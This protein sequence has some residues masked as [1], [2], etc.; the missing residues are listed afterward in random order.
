MA[1]TGQTMKENRL[2]LFSSFFSYFIG[3]CPP[4]L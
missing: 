2:G 3:V 1:V 4:L